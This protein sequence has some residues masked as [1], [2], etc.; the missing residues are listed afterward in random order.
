MAKICSGPVSLST[1]ALEI[2]W[3]HEREKK[4]WDYSGAGL[5]KI[6]EGERTMRMNFL[7]TLTLN[8]FFYSCIKRWYEAPQL[9]RLGGRLDGLR[10]LE[11]GCGNGVGAELLLTRFGASEVHAFDLD[12][13]MVAR[14]QRRLLPFGPERAKVYRGDASHINAPDHSYDAVVNFA[15]LHH[16]PDWQAAL[17]EIARVLKPGGLFLFEDVTKQWILRWP[18][19]VL[20]EHPMENRFSARELL[21]ELETTGIKVGTDYL[22]TGGGDFIFGVGR[23]TLKMDKLNST[24][25][26]ETR[27]KPPVLTGS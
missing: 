24:K 21:D 15:V 18:W 10:V 7:E 14:A 2:P 3:P 13:K 11:I 1:A 26:E 4:A 6:I 23:Y 27:V 19:R 8:N 20:F 22:E 16:I 17:R 25:Q 5:H 12:E 9:L